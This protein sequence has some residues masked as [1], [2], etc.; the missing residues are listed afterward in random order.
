M[1]ARAANEGRVL[2]QPFV[3][4]GR[5]TCGDLPAARRREWLITNGLGGYAMGTLSGIPTRRYHG[6][7]VAALA[8]PV[9]RTV[10]VAG[11][12]EW[13]VAGER[14]IP[15][16][17][18]EFADGAVAPDG[19]RAL[20]SFELDGSLPVWH[21]ADDDILL[22]RRAWMVHGANV[23]VVRYRL[24]RG[25]AVRIEVTPLVTC[26]DHHVLRTG[27]SA[28]TH[29]GPTRGGIRVH[30][31]RSDVALDLTADQGHFVDGAAWWLGFRHSEEAARGLDDLS[32]LYPAGTFHAELA[33]GISLEL[34]MS[35]VTDGRAQPA[36]D[37]PQGGGRARAR[38][39][40]AGRCP[41]RAGPGP[42]AGPGGGPVPGGASPGR[43]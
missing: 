7:L 17:S 12:D 43:R 9:D 23:T 26:R 41:R 2:E 32:D 13:L 25:P 33:P 15:L 5:E 30:F 40:G 36:R 11:L 22:E 27:R 34:T 28:V 42:P 10:L 35:A 31:D 6:W 8:P 14:R 4:L 16:S 39:A 20:E 37:L 21:F 19:W 24:L 3:S 1:N 18:F 29:T 38:P